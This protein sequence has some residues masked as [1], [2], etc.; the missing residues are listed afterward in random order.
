MG[1]IEMEVNFG[2]RKE[3]LKRKKIF[4]LS[5][6]VICCMFGDEKGGIKFIF[7]RLKL[8]VLLEI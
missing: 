3:V 8:M 6:W 1:G 7:K 2:V 5:E 4:V